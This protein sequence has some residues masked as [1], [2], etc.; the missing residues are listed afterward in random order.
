MSLSE[1]FKKVLIKDDQYVLYSNLSETVVSLEYFQDQS[2][3]EQQIRR[4]YD[5]VSTHRY[6]AC[7]IKVNG[8]NLIPFEDATWIEKL[9]LP[10]LCRSGILLMAYISANNV[11]SSLEIEKEILA[12]E[13]KKIKIRIFKNTE[14]A[15]VWFQSNHI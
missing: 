5:V 12:D 11:F 2:L 1:L 14:E 3:N 7:M 6:V 8:G 9:N 15:I 10:V 13:M 4:I